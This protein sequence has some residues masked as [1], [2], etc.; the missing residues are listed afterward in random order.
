VFEE[1][2]SG[3]QRDRP[4]LKA[5]LDYMR[6]GDTLVVWKLDRLARLLRSE[7]V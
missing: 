5:A 2:A 7:L 1:K 6:T 3:A 4:A